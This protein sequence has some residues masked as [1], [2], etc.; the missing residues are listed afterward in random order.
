MKWLIVSILL[1]ICIVGA[2][3]I[4]KG[5][6]QKYL[7][8]QPS[9]LEKSIAVLP[10]RNLSN[11]SLQAYFCDG[12]MEEILNNLQRVNEFT[13]RSRT[14]TEQYRK[15]SKSIKTIGE[16]MN[17]NYLIEGSVS[18]E[19]KNLKIWVQLINAKTDSHVWANDYTSEMKGLTREGD[20]NGDICLYQ[21]L[22]IFV[23]HSKKD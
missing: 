19:D 11:D 21:I 7:N 23:N 16:E 5:L 8:P 13:V 4:Y 1:L 2:N 15:T 17:V 12:F 10:F 20:E 22:K 3:L 9:K 14:S 18:K 6:K